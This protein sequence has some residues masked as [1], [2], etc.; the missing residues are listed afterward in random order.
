MKTWRGKRS[1]KESLRGRMPELVD[2]W[3]TAGRLA[4]MPGI[5]WDQVHRFRLL[6]KRFRYTLEIFRSAYGPG[7]ER[8]IEN[9]RELQTLLGDMND[10]VIT[11]SL[12][13]PLEGTEE[14]RTRL[15]RK[16]DKKKAQLEALWQRDFEPAARQANWRRYL[17]QYAC[18]TVKRD[19]QPVESPEGVVY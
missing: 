11:S 5:P 14:I 13:E 12:L 16:A 8:R 17:T 7:I 3:F 1:V 10:L 6:T 15:A 4:L 18:R 2:G 9:L 19:K